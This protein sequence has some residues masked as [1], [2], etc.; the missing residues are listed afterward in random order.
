MVEEN[1]SVYMLVTLVE[2]VAASEARVDRPGT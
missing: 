1:W 2:L